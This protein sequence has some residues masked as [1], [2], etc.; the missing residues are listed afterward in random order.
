MKSVFHGVY[1]LFSFVGH[2]PTGTL[3]AETCLRYIYYNIIAHAWQLDLRN[4]PDYQA[5]FD[6]SLRIIFHSSVDI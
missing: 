5:F 3:R 2:A 6:A 4:L 1:P